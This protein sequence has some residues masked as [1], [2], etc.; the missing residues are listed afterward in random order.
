MFSISVIEEYISVKIFFKIFLF[1]WHSLSEY[2][3]KVRQHVLN[4]LARL[5]NLMQF[6]SYFFH[7]F[8]FLD[9]QFTLLMAILQTILKATLFITKA[10]LSC[11]CFYIT[12]ISQSFSFS[13]EIIFTIMII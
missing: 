12:F 8:Y 2:L 11:I 1:C 5:L 6:F 7:F 9:K 3:L 13:N 10:W 4:N